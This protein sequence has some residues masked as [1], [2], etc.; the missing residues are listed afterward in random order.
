[1]G[2]FNPTPFSVHFSISFGSLFC[3]N[4]P[5]FCLCLSTLFLSLLS[6]NVTLG[7]CLCLITS[8]CLPG[9]ISGKEPFCQCRRHKRLGFD[10]WVMKIPWRRAWQPTPVFLPGGFPWTEEPGGLQ[11]MRSQR[12]RYDWSEF[13]PRRRQWQSIPVL[14]PGKFH[15]QRSL[16]GCS[17]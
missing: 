17:P 12:V 9:G 3:V 13:G 11:L 1:M 10:P 2:S 4:Q 6:G 7:Y 15:G 16:V 8:L 5:F 14:L